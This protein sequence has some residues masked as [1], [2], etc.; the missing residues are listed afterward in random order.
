MSV[1][2]VSTDGDQ[3]DV[4]DTVDVNAPDV[5]LANVKLKVVSEKWVWGV[6]GEQFYFELGAPS[7]SLADVLVDLYGK[8]K[9]IT[10]TTQK[11]NVREN[12]DSP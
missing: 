2:I 6:N 12:E 10:R 7:E 1:F 11:V 9:A 8:I 3:Y 4:G 5:G